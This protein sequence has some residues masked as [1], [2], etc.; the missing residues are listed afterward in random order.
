MTKARRHALL[1]LAGAISSLAARP[2]AAQWE[3][4]VPMSAPRRHSQSEL[5][6]G[7]ALIVAGAALSGIG[8]GV[9][10]Q[11][12]TRSCPAGQYLCGLDVGIAGFS[13]TILGGSLILAGIPLAMM[14]ASDHA[15]ERLELVLGGTALTTTGIGALGA[16]LTL[17]LLDG[18]SG[19]WAPGGVTTAAALF[20]GGAAVAGGGIAMYVLG[21]RRAKAAPLPAPS[22]PTWL[23]PP[24]IGLGPGFATLRWAI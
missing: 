23:A 24:E 9:V 21:N 3:D 5:E 14:G 22:S 17:A 7:V 19:D 1:A 2:A 16:G 12:E 8:A 13:T 11:G 18:R 10:A 15:P 4:P 6:T 20:A